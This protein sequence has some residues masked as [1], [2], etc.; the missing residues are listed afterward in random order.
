MDSQP[1]PPAPPPQQPQPELPQHDDAT[2]ALQKQIEG[3]RR[4]EQLQRQ[5]ASLPPQPMSREQRLEAWR[6]QGISDSEAAFFVRNPEMLDRPEVT[7]FA[8][9]KA[10]EAGLSRGTA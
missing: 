7:G 10:L 2:L 3:L 8:I 4:S 9:H 6:A 1:E 5:Q